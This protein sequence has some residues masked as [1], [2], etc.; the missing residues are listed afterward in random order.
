MIE[1]L[2][3]LA[4]GA[5]GYLLFGLFVMA[6]VGILIAASAWPVPS[7]TILFVLLA[8]CFGYMWRHL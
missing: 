4:I 7:L 1:L 6:L 5:I 3:C 2:K 8:G